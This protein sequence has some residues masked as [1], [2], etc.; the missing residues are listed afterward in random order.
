MTLSSAIAESPVRQTHNMIMSSAPT[1]SLERQTHNMTLSSAI[2][3]SLER[4]THHMTLS[5]APT[6]SPER[7]THHMTLSSARP[8][9][10][11]GSQPVSG[12][13]LC[14]NSLDN[15]FTSQV[16]LPS[17]TFALDHLAHRGQSLAVGHC[18]K[19][20]TV[21]AFSD[22]CFQGCC[23]V[24]LL[25]NAARLAILSCH[26]MLNMVHGKL[27]TVQWSLLEDTGKG[28]DC[29]IRSNH[30]HTATGRGSMSI[31]PAAKG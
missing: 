25:C 14:E 24:A 19:S 21:H 9:Q 6:E 4:Q 27:I 13:R 5:S 29:H 22:V 12:H 26:F 10:C 11:R 30:C 17:W 3:E 1:E 15:I 28:R 16:L 8:Y 31:H 18:C 2:A 20:T 7:Q 23:L